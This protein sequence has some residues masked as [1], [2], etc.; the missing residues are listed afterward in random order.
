[1]R[2]FSKNVQDITTGGGSPDTSGESRCSEF[3]KLVVACKTRIDE[4]TSGNV[5]ST[6]CPPNMQLG[7][8]YK[9]GKSA[10]SGRTMALAEEI[11]DEERELEM[12]EADAEAYRR[13]AKAEAD[14]RAAEAEADRQAAKTKKMAAE[15]DLM[16]K[17]GKKQVI[18]QPKKRKQ[19]PSSRS[20]TTSSVRSS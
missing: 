6:F 14:R 9:S 4:L 10:R 11:I 5:D 7:F 3:E 19:E 2:D 13:A 15:Q 16:L 1:M 8:S 18:I 17:S 12:L 20:S